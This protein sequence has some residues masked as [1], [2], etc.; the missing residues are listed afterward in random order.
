MFIREG[1]RSSRDGGGGGRPSHSFSKRRW[2]EEEEEEGRQSQG[3]RGGEGLFRDS[4]K[5]QDRRCARW[6]LIG[7]GGQ[8]PGLPFLL[9]PSQRRIDLWGHPRPPLH[10]SAAPEGRP[11]SWDNTEGW[12]IIVKSWLS[13]IFC[14]NSEKFHCL[15]YNKI[16]RRIGHCKKAVFCACQL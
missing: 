13:N 9:P 2:E 3:S 16:T 14:M 4:P 11:N 12:R 6:P 1:G 5:P 15:L 7:E 8:I 10:P